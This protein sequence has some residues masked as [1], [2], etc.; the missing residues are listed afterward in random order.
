MDKANSEDTESVCVITTPLTSN[1]VDLLLGEMR[2]ARILVSLRPA[3]VINSDPHFRWIVPRNAVNGMGEQPELKQK[4]VITIS[5][6][7]I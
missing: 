6:I 3:V 4:Q 5:G 1:I 7:A 2:Q